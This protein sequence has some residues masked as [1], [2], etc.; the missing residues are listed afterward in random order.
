MSRLSLQCPL[1]EAFVKAVA[2]HPDAIAISSP[3]STHADV[4]YAELGARVESL[5]RHLKRLGACEGALVEILLPQCVAEAV[6]VLSCV[7]AGLVY[8]PSTPDTTVHTQVLLTSSAAASEGPKSSSAHTLTLMEDDGSV[9]GFTASKESSDAHPT[10]QSKCSSGSDQGPP[11]LALLP[12]S[13]STG[14]PKMV[15]ATRRGALNRLAWGWKTFPFTERDKV[16]VRRT[17]LSFVDS[18]QEIL[19]ALLSG[20]EL[21][22]PATSLDPS[23]L[24]VTARATRITLTPSLLAL[25]LARS[26]S[27]KQSQSPSLSQSPPSVPA[28]HHHPHWLSHS[29][30][31]AL[32]FVSGEALPVALARQFSESL[33]GSVRLVNLYGTTEVAGDVTWASFEDIVTGKEDAIACIG[34]PISGVSVKVVDDELKPVPAGTVGQIF[35]TGECLAYGYHHDPEQTRKC[36]VAEG[37]CTGDLG[38]FNQSDGLLHW[39][40]RAEKGDDTKVRGVRVNLPGLQ[41]KISRAL[42]L[43]ISSLAVAVKSQEDG[44]EPHRTQLVCFYEAGVDAGRGDMRDGRSP[45]LLAEKLAEVLPMVEVPL[46][47]PLRHQRIPHTASGKVDRQGLLLAWGHS[48]FEADVMASIPGKAGAVDSGDLSLLTGRELLRE[49]LAGL[50]PWAGESLKRW[51]SGGNSWAGLSFTSLG[52][53]SLLAVEAAWKIGFRLDHVELLTKTLEEVAWV[54]GV[55][56]SQQQR[57]GWPS[58]NDE[59]H[60]KNKRFRVKGSKATALDKGA[61]SAQQPE[62]QAPYALDVAAAW[63]VEMGKCVDATPLVANGLV[64]VGAHSAL[65]KAIDLATGTVKWTQKL[66]GRIEAS[67]AASNDGKLIYIGC[68]DG[69]LYAL[70]QQTGEV[71]WKC[72]TGDAIKCRA[73]MAGAGDLVIG[74]HDHFLR[75]L[76]QQYGQLVWEAD[77]QG[78]IFASPT[79]SKASGLVHAATTGGRLLG[80]H[81]KTGALSW[82]FQAPAPLFSSPLLTD[83]GEVII[84]CVN[85]HAYC[86]DEA[87]GTSKW[88]VNC[89]ESPIFSSPCIAED[90]SILMGCNDGILRCLEHSSGSVKWS[91]GLGSAICS[92]PHQSSLELNGSKKQIRLVAACCTDGTVWCG[93][94]DGATVGVFKVPGEVFAAPVLVQLEGTGCDT[95]LALVSCRDERVYAFRW[96]L[97]VEEQLEVGEQ[98][99]GAGT[100]PLLV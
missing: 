71:R 95:G 46:M 80:V 37:Y 59:E 93:T 8:V 2:T 56:K 13:G 51:A 32:C 42:D 34:R 90:G 1:A 38:Y 26:T 69:L 64:Y 50:L 86:V 29:P 98:E 58:P 100:T 18:I 4:T 77:C 88:D 25:A 22:Y 72:S 94:T 61:A 17:P 47:V 76:T 7:S 84:G 16:V 60:A 24:L 82:A 23:S 31:L 19:G 11:L 33:G 55:R 63:A 48:A 30:D 43:P 70:D 99:G 92:A 21:L 40:G 57:S 36:F 75:C 66:G 41:I 28:P 73:A 74:S 45:A 35:V 96:S 68:Y 54:V 65:F 49:V 27:L 10:K 83:S 62:E 97:R 12:T 3:A 5:V 52:G 81:H 39:C 15:R 87:L 78:A 89:S 20:A 67:A 53:T 9:A 79:S 44:A 91:K 14:K 6:A 85:G